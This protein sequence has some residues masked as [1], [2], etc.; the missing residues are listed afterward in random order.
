MPTPIGGTGGG[1][2]GMRDDHVSSS[3]TKF[4]GSS[5]IGAARHNIFDRALN[6]SAN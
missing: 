1:G 5:A 3:M 4:R 2:G 6:S